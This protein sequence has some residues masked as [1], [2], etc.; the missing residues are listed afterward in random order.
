MQQQVYGLTEKVW[1]RLLRESGHVEEKGEAMTLKSR[2]GELLRRKVKGSG[3][4][5]GFNKTWADIL[6]FHRSYFLHG[7]LLYTT[8]LSTSLF[9]LRLHHQFI[10][11]FIFCYIILF[12]LSLNFIGFFSF[13]FFTG[14][15]APSASRRRCRPHPSSGS[16]RRGT[17]GCGWRYWSPCVP[18]R[19]GTAASRSR[20]PSGRAPARR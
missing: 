5:K 6:K 17:A 13:L 2:S 20:P 10:S 9:Y 18:P 1:R 15:P 19:S 8:V 11:L 7:Y 14:I 12:F 4:R 16:R 3:E